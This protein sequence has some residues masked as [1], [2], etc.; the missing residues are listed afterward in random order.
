MRRALL[1]LVALPLLAG[2]GVV[3]SGAPGETTEFGFTVQSDPTLWVTFVASF[4]LF[5]TN[6]SLGFYSDII[7]TE[8]GPTDFALPPGAPDWTTQLGSFTID[9]SA[10][11]TAEDSGTIR[12]LFQRY[13]G[14]PGV[15]SATC[16]VD[17][18][19]M[20]VP[21][22]VTVTSAPAPEPGTW[23]L[24]IAGIGFMVRRGRAG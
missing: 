8:G 11:P 18:G 2:A 4:T 9:P 12:V 24:L 21:F 22:Q 3:A 10:L 6:P 15:C 20:D 1:G 17:A 7:G 14:D 23:V 16:F 5:E 13:A 19:S